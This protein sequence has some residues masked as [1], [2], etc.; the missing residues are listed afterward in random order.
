MNKIPVVCLPIT[1]EEA[2]EQAEANL[3][4]IQASPALDEAGREFLR[5]LRLNIPPRAKMHR[6]FEAADQVS[7]AIL[8]HSACKSGCSY[9]CH[10]ATTITSTE[11]EALGKVS[12]RK[13]RKL[14]GHTRAEDQREQWH[15]V[16][17]PFLKAG[18][19]SVYEVRPMACRLMQ[20]IADSPY[21]CDTAVPSKESLV[22]SVDLNQLQAAYAVAYMDD[23]WADIRDFFPPVGAKNG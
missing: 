1:K 19:C 8:P 3:L 14:S 11:A 7:R 21:F 15:T 5:A 2:M 18:R 9:C 17:C 12:G 20:N 16:P 6:L 4:K 22:T 10:I 23:T 13:P